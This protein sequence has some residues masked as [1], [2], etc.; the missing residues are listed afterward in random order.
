MNSEQGVVQVAL[1]QLTLAKVAM[2]QVAEHQITDPMG[3]VRISPPV[4]LSAKRTAELVT[5][6]LN[7][8][9]QRSGSGSCCIKG[10]NPTSSKNVLILRWVL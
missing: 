3:K 9:L 5:R 1:A 6:L 2:A 8:K 4:R 7:L 10:S